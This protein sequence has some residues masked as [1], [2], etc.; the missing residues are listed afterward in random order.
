M[1]KILFVANVAKEH[2]MKFHLPQMRVFREHGWQVDVACAGDEIIPDCDRQFHASWKRSPFTPKTFKGIRELTAI[3]NE[4]QYDIVY[5]HTPV[6]GLVARLAARKA[7][8]HGTKV[9]YC[10]HGLHFF[11]GAPLVNWLLFYPIEKWLARYTDVFFAVNTEDYATVQKHLSDRMI[12]T[13]VPEVGA[14]FTRL[15]IGDRAAVR[16]EY[17]RS[18]GI[19]DD[20]PVLIYVAE[21][22]ANKNQS[23]LVD[24]LGELHKTIPNAHLLLVGPEHDDGALKAYIDK[25]GLNNSVTLAGW[26]SDIGQLMSASDVCVASSIREGFGINL[27]EAMYCGLPVVATDN[28]GHR[29][30]ITDG[31]NGFLVPL[32]APAVMASR[33]EQ[34]LADRELYARLSKTDVAQFDCEHVA[35]ILYNEIAQYAPMQQKESITT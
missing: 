18:L 6:G 20:T 16:A 22:I 12:K 2:I 5:C 35:E 27:V 29:S 31:E 19:D 33:V 34:L 26:R 7:R 21:L 11:K 4:N 24:M 30:V 1:N 15:Q 3:L 28:R 25:C 14:N 23:L 17:R 10:A 9:I 13:L 32:G 8:K